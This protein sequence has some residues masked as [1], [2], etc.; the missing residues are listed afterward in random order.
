MDDVRKMLPQTWQWRTSKL[1]C[2]FL[3]FM[4]PSKIFLYTNMSSFIMSKLLISSSSSSKGIQLMPHEIDNLFKSLNGKLFFSNYLIIWDINIDLVVS[5][6]LSLR[7]FFVLLRGAYTQNI[8]NII[9]L[10][11]SCCI[12]NLIFFLNQYIYI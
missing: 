2:L 3:C 6:D 10:I 12:I 1:W 11:L 4:D 7:N 8:R 5:N 9:Y